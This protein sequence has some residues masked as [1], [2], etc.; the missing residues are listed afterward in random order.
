[1]NL[2]PHHKAARILAG[3]IVL[4]VLV[5]FWLACRKFEFST[6]E[7]G[8]IA[9]VNHVFWSSL[10]GKFF[11][12]FGIDRSY[13]AMHQEILLFLFWPLYALIPSPK[14]LFFVQ[15][16]CIAVSAVPMFLIAR[17][18][19]GDDWSALFMAVALIMFPSIVSQNANQLHTSQWV[20]PLLLACFYF[21]LKEDYR[22][23]VVFCI[24]AALGKE[25]TP[26]TLLMFVPYALWKRRAKKWWITPAA[27][28]VCS[29][30]LSFKIIGPYFARGWEYEALGYMSNLGNTWGEV[31]AALF[32]PKL[33]Q[34]LFQP[35]NGPY[36]LQL[37]QPAVWILPFFAPEVIFVAPDLGTNLLAGNIGLKVPVWHYNV[38]TGAFLVLACTFSI[39]NLERW[40]KTRLRPVLPALV[41]A[42][43][44]AHW[45]F[46]LNPREYRPLPHYEAQKQARELIPPAASVLIGPQLMV[47]HFSD[48]LKFTTND[49]VNNDPQ[50]MFEYDWAFFDLNYR[51]YSP[52]LPEETVRAFASNPDYELVFS[53]QN[54]LV[55]RRKDHGNR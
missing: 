21:F 42:F 27:V 28:S 43:A 31:I 3:L 8:D 49:R 11:W 22:W 7:M 48:R 20:L 25:N 53:E 36:L 18:V 33:F 39:M 29:L 47:G 35:A 38:Y 6:A 40:L 2:I 12:H 37:L 55:F 45:P 13:F 17:R 16:F 23:F 52:P 41:C 44:I 14:T 32:S 1:M 46:W 24:L 15:T 19:F 5:F 51:G 30:I 54:V 9:A 10:H 34:A 4:Y 26:L 50:K